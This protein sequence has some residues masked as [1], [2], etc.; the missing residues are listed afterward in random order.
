MKSIIR[1]QIFF[2]WVSNLSNFFKRIPPELYALKLYK[3]FPLADMGS[4]SHN[5]HRATDNGC[6]SAGVPMMPQQRK[7]V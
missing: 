4:S 5:D 2:I 3:A 1:K 7:V 6:K